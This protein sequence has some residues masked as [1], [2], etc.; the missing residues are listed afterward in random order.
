MSSQK[1]AYAAALQLR[2]NITAATSSSRDFAS[3][4]ANSAPA[5]R[6]FVTAHAAA[7]REAASNAASIS[8][9]EQ[10]LST[11]AQ[12]QATCLLQLMTQLEASI[13]GLRSTLDSAHKLLEQPANVID[14]AL[15]VTYAARL[16]HHFYPLGTTPGLPAVPPAPQP[17][18]MLASSLNQWNAVQQKALEALQAQQE[19]Q[20]AAEARRAA[21]MLALMPDDWVPGDP[22]PPHVTA[23]LA[24]ADRG[25][26][27]VAA[28]KAAAAGGEGSTPA[29]DQPGAAA[30]AGMSAA[31]AAAPRVALGFGLNADLGE[32]VS[33]EWS[34]DDDDM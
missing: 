2:D 3:C 25:K 33:E 5:L 27:P 19:A 16:R 11:A 13:E 1:E 28:A 15:V 22:I 7:T 31:A 21:I 23:A 12:H 10:E 8:E 4:L 9:Q 30:A 17:P 26:D 14:P 6:R 20:A 18:F 29:A 24:A 32:E 34:D